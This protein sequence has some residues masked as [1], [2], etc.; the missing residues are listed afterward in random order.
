M[1]YTTRCDLKLGK[2]FSLSPGGCSRAPALGGL[3]RMGW[4]QGWA[5]FR[6]AQG[7]AA[8]GIVFAAFVKGVSGMGFRVIGAPS[9]ALF[10]DPQTTVVAITIPAFV[11]SVI[12]AF[13]G[14]V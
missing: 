10:L 12:Q 9:A 3:A 4:R 13:Q 8:L 11:M 14:G 6:P 1:E 7:L 2:L 5:A